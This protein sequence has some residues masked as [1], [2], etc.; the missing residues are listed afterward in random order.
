VKLVPFSEANVQG[1]SHYLDA[2]IRLMIERG[3]LTGNRGGLDASRP[4]CH[5]KKHSEDRGEGSGHP[6]HV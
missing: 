2:C 4:F 1:F 5:A 3:G 6:N